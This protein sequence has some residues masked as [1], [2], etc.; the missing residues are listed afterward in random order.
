M[1]GGAPIP[2]KTPARPKQAATPDEAAKARIRQA[3]LGPIQA[4]HFN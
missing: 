4:D 2:P 3:E 1:G